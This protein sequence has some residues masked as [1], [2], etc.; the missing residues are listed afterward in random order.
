MSDQETPV[1]ESVSL[2]T[3]VAILL[4]VVCYL[5]AL[6]DVPLLAPGLLWLATAL[7]GAFPALARLPGAQI[8]MLASSAAVRE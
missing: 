8:P 7:Y 1:Q 6:N 3:I 5:A 2:I 4:A